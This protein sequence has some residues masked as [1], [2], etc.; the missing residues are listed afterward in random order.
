MIHDSKEG[1]VEMS[2]AKISAVMFRRNVLPAFSLGVGL[3][4]YWATFVQSACAQQTGSI[5]IVSVQ[6]A[7]KPAT[8]SLPRV[9]TETVTISDNAAFPSQITRKQGKFFLRIVNQTKRSRFNLALESPALPLT[10]V[11]GLA[12]A[13]N[14]AAFQNLKH[15]AGEFNAAPGEYRLKSQSTGK[16]LCVIT[17]N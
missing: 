13:I 3:F 11:S 17:I 10:V 6:T 12:Q 14:L 16:V 9:E 1:V 7:T 4:F 2:Q 5:T 8:G 15:T